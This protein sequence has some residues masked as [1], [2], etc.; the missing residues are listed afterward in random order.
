M[1]ILAP[2]KAYF[3]YAMELK[4]HVP[5]IAYYCKLYAVNRGFDLMKQNAGNPQI[6]EVKAY[7]IGE[8][9][10][11]EQM[12]GALGASTKEDHYPQVENFIFSVFAKIDKEER[13]D[14]QVTKVHALG[15]K[16][17]ADFI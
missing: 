14:P 5:V 6:N 7:L 3:K 15:F 9:K 11:L 2:V 8:L 10:D 17:C 16:R 4:Q 13:N 1:S 12:K